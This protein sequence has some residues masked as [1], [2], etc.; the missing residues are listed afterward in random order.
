MTSLDPALQIRLEKLLG[1]AIVTFARVERGYTPASRWIVR[2]ATGCFFAK[3][4]TTPLTANLLRREAH[5]Y[6]AIR[7]DFMPDLIGWQD[8]ATKPILIIEDLSDAQWPPPWDQRQIALVL[9]QIEALHNTLA[10]VPPYEEIH[11]QRENNWEI[12][13]D[14]PGPF[15]SLG[16]AS[17]Q[18]LWRALPSL[19]EAERCCTTQGHQ[20]THWDIRSDNL[21]IT[22]KGVKFVDWA[23]ACLSN[24]EL[25]LG[26][27]LPSLAYEGGPEPEKILPG[28]PE[29]AAWV[30]GFFAARAGLPLIPDAP[31]VRLVQRQ[32]LET[33]LPWAVRA[34]D[35]PPLRKT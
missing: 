33:A 30:A 3:V 13:A 7:G 35:L 32:Q 14:D 26:F 8:H 21:C 18:W 19:L 24:P 34:L 20:L 5:S 11:G 4:A 16:L 6:Q 9:N 25:D 10:N 12:V 22:P 27:W 15:L 1:C 2:T 28:A 23:E 29:V 17:D 31:H